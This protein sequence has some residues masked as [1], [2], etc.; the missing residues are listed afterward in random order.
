MDKAFLPKILPVVE[1]DG[2]KAK[3]HHPHLPKVGCGVAGGGSLLLMIS[4]VKTGKCLAFFTLVETTNGNKYIKDVKVGDK[5]LSDKGYVKVTEKFNQGKKKCFTI[6]LENNNEIILTEEHKLH[7]LKGM[8][9]M[10]DCDDDMIITKTGMSKIKSKEFFGELDCYDI[11]VDSKDHRFFANNISVSNSTIISNLL[12]SDLCYSQDF[13]DDVQ[14]I[15]NTIKNDVTSRFLNKAFNVYDYYSDSI[16]EGI[17]DRQKSFQ[18]EDQPEMAL[19]L[20]DCLGSIK[21]ESKI[22]H[23][24]SRYRH[25]NIKLLIIS[26]QKFKGSVSP[27]IRANATDVIIG[28]PFP[29]QK[30][31][32]AV[33]EEYGDL[34]NGPENWLRLYRK[35]TPNKYDFCYMDLQSNPPIMYSNFE[36]QIA[37]GGYKTDMDKDDT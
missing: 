5:V 17:I 36:K 33:A 27:I 30:E 8:K 13:F 1:P 22:N 26:S 20:D 12:L 6:T 19:V 4:P 31:L 9:Q 23:L 11:T 3:P 25:F 24:C 28:S 29:N 15:S 2:V 35:A 16:I 14:I 32:M 7:T 10:K 34:F 18:K 21:R 37:T